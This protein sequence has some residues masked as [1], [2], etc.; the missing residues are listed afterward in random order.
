MSEDYAAD[1]PQW[2]ESHA[3][4]RRECGCE[5]GSDADVI[6]LPRGSESSTWERVDLAE[7]TLD[8]IERPK[9]E[10]GTLG[11]QVPLFYRGKIHAIYGESEAGKTW[12][13]YQAILEAVRDGHGALILDFEDTAQT[14]AMRFLTLQATP[15]ELSR[16]AFIAPSSAITD[17]GAREALRAAIAAVEPSIVFIDGTTEAMAIHGLNPLDNVDIANFTRRLLRPLAGLEF[18][19]AVVTSD[20][21][22]KS[23]ESRGRY[24]IGGIHKLN[25]IDGASYQLESVS[26]IRPG[27]IGR[28][29]V[30][31]TKDRS[32]SVREH[33]VT[34]S[35]GRQWIGTLTI[36]G[37][38]LPGILEVS[39]EP[40]S[41][42]EIPD[43]DATDPKLYRRIHELLERQP[44]LG[45]GEIKA[46]I[47]G[48][49]A[50]INRALAALEDDGSITVEHGTRGKK[51]HSINRDR[52]ES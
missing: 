28:S 22:V 13:A 37:A 29:K 51:S 27:A 20:H 4:A 45:V 25:I 30:Y 11:G 7:L 34:E 47:S 39:L 42:T 9:P 15:E 46:R 41:A 49:S 40:A 1:T 17:A 36:D 26:P 32:G 18:R 23:T 19:P 50:D 6:E 8:G 38:S 35:K 21:V 48:R 24:A 2:C 44:G 10:I 16:I 43:P 31:V 3:L 14:A 52:E 33:A 12:L 5:Y